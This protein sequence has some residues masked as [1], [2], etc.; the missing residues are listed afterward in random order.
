[1]KW[2]A[3]DTGPIMM[4]GILT[5]DDILIALQAAQ[6]MANRMSRPMVLMDDLS[7]QEV[8]RYTEAKAVEIIHPM[9]SDYVRSRDDR[10]E[11]R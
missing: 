5:V 11:Y 7:V 10:Q 3:L 1:M 9:R 6:A 4:I 8:T 2:F